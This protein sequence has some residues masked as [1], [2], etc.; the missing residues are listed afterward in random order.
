M[1]HQTIYQIIYDVVTKTKRSDKKITV[2]HSPLT[3]SH[4]AVKLVVTMHYNMF[5]DSSA[6]GCLN[7][8]KT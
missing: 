1:I 4:I 5:N 6:R 3:H 7:T 8:S 2:G